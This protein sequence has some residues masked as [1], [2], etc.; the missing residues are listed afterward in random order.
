MNTFARMVRSS[1]RLMIKFLHK[2]SLISNNNLQQRMIFFTFQNRYFGNAITVEKLKQIVI[3]SDIHHASAEEKALGLSENRAIRKPLA[4]WAARS[5][6]Y[7]IWLRN[8]L[9]HNYLIDDFLRACGSPDWVIANGDYSNDS[10][11][12]GVS[13]PVTFRSVQECFGRFRSCFGSRFIPNYGDHE[14]GKMSLF[15]GVGGLRL[16]S[17]HATIDK[18]GMVPFWETR[19]GRIRLAGMVSSLIALPVYEPETTANER[20]AWHDIRTIHL[21]NIGAFFRSLKPDEKAILF[22]H[23]PTALPFL[24]QL[25]DVQSRTAQIEQTFIGHL[26]SELILWKSRLLAGMPEIRFLGNA[27]RRMSAALR[28]ARCWSEFKVRLCPSLAGIQLLKDGGYYRLHIDPEGRIP[29]RYE[30][31]RLKWRDPIIGN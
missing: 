1:I 6:R 16:A 24:L 4:K 28:K 22:C 5:F 10:A 20:S 25:P 11:F 14:L 12:T 15:G 3:V 8:P 30:R 19:I 23:D 18:L 7:F 29:I 2:L 31:C 21:E 27:V 9:S 17:W 13:D 26:H